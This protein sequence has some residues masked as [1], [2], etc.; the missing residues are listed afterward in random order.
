MNY[1]RGD[2]NSKNNQDSSTLLKWIALAFCC[3]CSIVLVGSII[4]VLREAFFV[5]D[6]IEWN[7]LNKQREKTRNSLNEF[8]EGKI[9]STEN[10]KK[11]P[12][13]ENLIK[14][15]EVK[16]DQGGSEI[17]EN[18]INTNIRKKSADSIFESKS[19]KFVHVSLSAGVNKRSYFEIT[20]PRKLSG[21]AFQSSKL[22]I[23][24]SSEVKINSKTILE[25]PSENNNS[26]DNS[27]E[28]RNN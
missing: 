14:P 16:T 22:S 18:K 2:D 17:V 26:N 10:D 20:Q 8:D 21:E 4:Y 27:F 25:N 15:I 3:F 1:F 28:N 7:I 13:I 23:E 12:D 11:V 19:V 6:I 24:N 5:E 9:N